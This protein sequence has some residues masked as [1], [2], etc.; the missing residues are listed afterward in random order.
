MT[1]TGPRW[2]T[3]TPPRAGRDPVRGCGPIRRREAAAKA[4]AWPG[5]WTVEEEGER[6]AEPHLLHLLRHLLGGHAGPRP[7]RRGADG[8]RK[9]ADSAPCP[10]QIR[11]CEGGVPVPQCSP[12]PS[13]RN[14]RGPRP[15]PS[16]TPPFPQGPAP[17]AWAGPR[18]PLSQPVPVLLL[19]RT[20]GCL[21]H[22]QRKLLSVSGLVL[23][24]LLPVHLGGLQDVRI[25][26]SPDWH[27]RDPWGQPA[28]AS[29]SDPWSC[30]DGSPSVASG[31]STPLL[32][33][34]SAHKSYY[35]CPRL[36]PPP[37]QKRFAPFGALNPFANPGYSRS[38]SSS[39]AEWQ[40][41]PNAGGPPRCAPRP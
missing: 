34:D 26:P 3:G 17:K 7:H 33:T 25:R 24:V 38:P 4:G 36:K 23:P 30:A 37:S 11:S 16:C 29:W 10:A 22:P 39:P 21:W 31:R 12:C 35:S 8:G 14:Q 18:L 19:I 6:R 32:S 15:Q 41:P 20:A 2:S 40:D 28:Q 1:P 5:G 27:Q 9:S 13:Q